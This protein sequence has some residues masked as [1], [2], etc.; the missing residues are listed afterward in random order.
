VGC[1]QLHFLVDIGCAHVQRPTEDPGERQHVVDLVGIVTPP[2]GHHRD[3]VVDVLR[4]HLRVGI[5]HGVD[6]TTFVHAL[7]VAS[8]QHIRARHTHEDVRAGDHVL[9]RPG[10][11]PRVGVGNQPLF[12]RFIGKLA[13]PV[14]RAAAVAYDDVLETESGH[15]LRARHPGGPRTRDHHLEAFR[16]PVLQLE[17][18]DDTG[19]QHHRRTVLVVVENRDV[20]FLAQCFLYVEALGRLDVLEV[21]T[22]EAGGHLPAEIDDAVG[23][24]L[25]DAQGKRVHPAEL[26]EEDCLS[27]HHRHGRLG[28]DVAQAQH[29]TPVGHHRHHVLAHG[30]VVRE[31]GLIV[32]SPAY[33]R[34][35]RCVGHGEVC[36]RFQRDP[37][38][39]LELAP[40]VH[41]KGLVRNEM[42]LDALDRFDRFDDLVR[43]LG[44]S[45]IHR[46]VAHTHA[47]A[48]VY[49][50]DGADRATLLCD[51]DG[52]PREP[53]GLVRVFKPHGDGV[54]GAGM[55]C[56][57]HEE[58]PYKYPHNIM[59][60]RRRP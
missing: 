42:K 37:G 10:L 14:N 27:L 46:V 59:R 8:I 35:T 30:E 58:P 6:E 52:N 55:S 23:V 21:D 3:D 34:H 38:C 31:G 45:R 28:A 12:G 18:I 20:Q 56:S 32:D 33:A 1:G 39:N 9:E 53:P 24:L 22:A 15:D 51:D 57:F 11:S 54:L 5:A 4:L 60:R 25:V 17:R 41:V 48:D 7:H 13:T 49:Q 36:A 44:C 43:L 47:A 50:V 29:G 40:H 26:L 2:R 16:P 19:Q